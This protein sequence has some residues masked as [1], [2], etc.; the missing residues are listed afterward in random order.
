MPG[1]QDRGK[2][3]KEG[4]SNRKIVKT[5]NEVTKNID[6]FNYISIWNLWTFKVIMNKLRGKRHT[7]VKS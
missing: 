1:R 3:R 6:S 7:G 5:I 2:G 4:K